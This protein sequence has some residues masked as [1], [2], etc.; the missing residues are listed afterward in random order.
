[1]PQAVTLAFGGGGAGSGGGSGP[2]SSSGQ[3]IV[4][5]VDAHTG[6]PLA[7]TAVRIDGAS[8]A[9]A[10][11][12][13]N[14]MIAFMGLTPGHYS[15][16]A[17]DAGYGSV[18]SQVFN[19]DASSASSLRLSLTSTRLRQQTRASSTLQ[20]RPALTPASAQALGSRAMLCVTRRTPSRSTTL[21][22]N[23]RR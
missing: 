23:S 22:T 12:D 15:V 16:G 13:G 1:V 20:Q 4:Q 10:V 5:V 8:S 18:R 2:G 6:A 7:N 21:C 14:G 19:V 17:A 9:S 11:T 3:I